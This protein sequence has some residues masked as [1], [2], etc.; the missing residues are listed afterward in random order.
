MDLRVQL[1]QDYNEGE[2]IAAL[3]GI[4]QVSRKTVYKWLARHD[5][6]GAAGLA[7]R[8][9]VPLLM[10]SSRTSSRRA[11]GGIGGR[12]SCGSS[13]PPRIRRS[14]GRPSRPSA[15]C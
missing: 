4:Y 9:R 12:A 13:W 11:S 14:R 7:D 1:I 8:S 2:N 6:E 3:A 10:T 5:A 15:K